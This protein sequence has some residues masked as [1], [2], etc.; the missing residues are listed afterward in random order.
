MM[1]NHRLSIQLQSEM[2][3]Q[4]KRRHTVS[5]SKRRH[6]SLQ[7]NAVVESPVRVEASCGSSAGFEQALELAALDRAMPGD[8][9]RAA[10]IKSRKD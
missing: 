5:F 6:H 7:R 3:Q 4:S 2:P 9:E 8:I 10:K 1:Q